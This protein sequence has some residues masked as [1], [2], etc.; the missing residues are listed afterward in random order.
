MPDLD[1]DSRYESEL[2]GAFP[3]RIVN[4]GAILAQDPNFSIVVDVRGV[5]QQVAGSG[6]AL[7]MNEGGTVVGFI[8]S[9]A[10]T[11]A[12]EWVP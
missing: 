4:S 10:L 8:F 11:F 9:G 3:I 1:I 6:T 2:D 7:D 5:V 12:A